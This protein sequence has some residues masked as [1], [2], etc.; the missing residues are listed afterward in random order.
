MRSTDE[1]LGVGARSDPEAILTTPHSK[2]WFN[3]MVFTL[4]ICLTF[5]LFVPFYSL[6][7]F[8]NASK[9]TIIWFQ[10]PPRGLQSTCYPF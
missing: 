3:E 1:T 2:P 8:L 10:N 4:S 9:H 7:F 5:Y 6:S